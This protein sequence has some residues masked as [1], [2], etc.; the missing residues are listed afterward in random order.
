[1]LLQPHN[2]PQHILRRFRAVE[3]MSIKSEEENAICQ[4]QTVIY[5]VKSGKIHSMYWNSPYLAPFQAK[6]KMETSPSP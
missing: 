2:K 3:I 4:S 5:S 6:W 1:M